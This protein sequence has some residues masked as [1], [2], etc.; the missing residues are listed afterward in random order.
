LLSVVTLAFLVTLTTTGV[1]R[2]Y[3]TQHAARILLAWVAGYLVLFNAVYQDGAGERPY[4]I[5]V[6]R[7]VEGAALAMPALAAIGL[8]ALWLRIDQHGLTP[9]RMWAVVAGAILTLYAVGYAAAVPSR[10][11]RWM[12]RVCRVNIALAV[13]VVAVALAMHTPLLDPLAWSARSQARRLESGSVTAADFDYGFLRFHLGRAGATALG[14]LRA[15]ASAPDADLIRDGVAAVF[16]AQQE[17]DWR[18]RLGRRFNAERFERQPPGSSWPDGLLEALGRES[19]DW[20]LAGCGRTVTC[21]VFDADVDADGT[22][23]ALVTGAGERLR[24]KEINVGVFRHT[25]TGWRL[26]GWM[27]PEAQD[28]AMEG[29]TL[30][31]IRANRVEV[32][33]PRQHDL[34]VDG[35]RFRLME[36]AK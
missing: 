27:R 26:V 12:P 2:L 8:H 29:D 6:R 17:S 4:T 1:T 23:E 13:V 14:Q 36:G 28:A 18:T 33:A 16:Q 31:A 21:V 34:L 7:S 15:S 19:A 25:E 30:A 35:T 3:A 9:E 22:P 5:A 20:R 24:P 32:V 11:A 10:D